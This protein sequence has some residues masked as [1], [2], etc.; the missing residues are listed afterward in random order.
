MRAISEPKVY[1][2]SRPELDWGQLAVF[3]MDE[4]L[5]DSETSPERPAVLA[6]QPESGIATRAERDAAG[7]VEAAARLC[8]MSY[9]KGRTSFTDFMDNL[10]AS[11]HGSVFEHVNYGMIF[12][13]VS[14]SL[15]HELVRHRVGM[16]Y[17]QLS[18][19]FVDESDVAF[20]IPPRIVEELDGN[21]YSEWSKACS[22]S[23]QM[24][25]AQL[26]R[27]RRAG[28]TRKE[29]NEAARA[30]LPNSTETKIFV[31]G[32]VRAWRHFLKLRGS[33]AADAEIQRLARVVHQRL[34]EECPALFGDI[35]LGDNGLQSPFVHV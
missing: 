27:M 12:T 17:S 1:I 28:G 15:T 22:T 2:V 7:L 5:L 20:V 6:S 11:G 14:R 30:V 24:Y 4:E 35:E 34:V 10:M 3:L 23:L 29:R 9:G 19:R 26:A 33:L 21:S 25:S 18:Q 16:S 31:T 13:G 32:N 8:Y